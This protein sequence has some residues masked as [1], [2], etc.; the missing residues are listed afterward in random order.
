MN[1]QELILNRKTKSKPVGSQI[2]NK[3]SPA[4]LFI[5]D[6][7]GFTE[8]VNN[9]EITHSQHIIH[10][11]LEEI[12]DANEIGLEVSEIEGDAV[13]FYRQGTAPTVAELLA[14]VQR[15]YTRFH[16]LIAKYETHRICHCGACTSANKLSLKF[17]AHYGDIVKRKL[18]RFQ[19]VFGKDVIV[20]HRLMKNEVPQDEYV[21]FTQELLD[22]CSTWVDLNSTAWTKPGNGDITYDFGTINYSFLTLKEL[23]KHIPLPSI[24]DY[25][26]PNASLKYLTSERIIS[27]PIELVFNVLTDLKFRAEWIPFLKDSDMLNSKITQHGSAHR[28]L[29]SEDETDPYVIGHSFNVRRDMITFVESESKMKLN[30]F[31]SLKRIGKGLTRIERIDCFKNGIINRFI[32]TIIKK[33]QHKDWI[34]GLMGNIKEYCEKL[35][36]EGKTHPYEIVLPEE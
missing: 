18:K 23:K 25:M 34:E 29:I 33:K 3:P 2:G 10:E 32:F 26:V 7:S 8:F 31:Y 11:L 15:M 30:V 36:I 14:Q 13:F 1:V 22:A 35:V 27:A 4:L 17:I 12:I 16:T 21:L 19:T 5:P 9:T 6:I 28:C 20:A 24:K